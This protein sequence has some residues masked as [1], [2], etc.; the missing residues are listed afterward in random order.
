MKLPK[1][2]PVGIVEVPEDY[3]RHPR[4]YSPAFRTAA[5]VTLGAFTGVGIVT[6]VW[7]LA[8]YCLTTWAGTPLALP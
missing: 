4:R 3:Q 2:S 7:T 1:V 8:A 6:T 5:L